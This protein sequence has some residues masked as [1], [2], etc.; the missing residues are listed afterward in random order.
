MIKLPDEKTKK[1]FTGYGVIN[2]SEIAQYEYCNVGWFLQRCGVK[3]ESPKLEEGI[4]RHVELGK[5]I[6]TFHY[7][8]ISS[9]KISFVGYALVLIA[10]I[11]LVVGL[12]LLL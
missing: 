4:S 9:R 1:K 10:I 3:P 5:Q 2:A 6:D 8:E 7:Q 12:L 11:S